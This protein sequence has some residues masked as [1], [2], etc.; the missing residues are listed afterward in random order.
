MMILKNMPDIE[1]A[2]N[3][4]SWKFLWDNWPALAD[5]IAAEVKRGAS[6]P[7]IRRHVMQHTQREAIAIR[8]RQAAQHLISQNETG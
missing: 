4:E 2:L 6:A 1:A 7:E 5:A 8:C 3:E